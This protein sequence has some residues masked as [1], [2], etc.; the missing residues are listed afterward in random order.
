MIIFL[1]YLS[2]LLGCYLFFILEAAEKHMRYD[3]KIYLCPS[4]KW[5]LAWLF[6]SLSGPLVL[7]IMLVQAAFTILFLMEYK[8]DFWNKRICGDEK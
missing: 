5:A 6:L 8:S 4:R 2:G 1:W 3:Y 7:P